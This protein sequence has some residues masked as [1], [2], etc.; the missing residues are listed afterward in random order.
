MECVECECVC[1]CVGVD[2]KVT[3]ISS[4]Q[5]RGYALSGWLVLDESL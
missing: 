3:A 5:G 4:A 2:G 1:L